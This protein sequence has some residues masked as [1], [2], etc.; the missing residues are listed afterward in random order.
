MNVSSNICQFSGFPVP[1]PIPATPSL[2]EV[3]SPGQQHVTW[4]SFHFIYTFLSM[5]KGAG[6]P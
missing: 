1:H 2:Q 3:T 6:F 5:A 4:W